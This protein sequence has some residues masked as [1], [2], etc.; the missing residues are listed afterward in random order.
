MPRRG[1]HIHK[2]KDGRWEARY[3][4]GIDANG[5]TCYKSV[6][7]KTYTE[8]KEKLWNCLKNNPKSE[9][10]ESS[11]TFGVAAD[12]WLEANKFRHKG[13][14][15]MRYE[16]L[17]N[18]HIKPE[19]QDMRLSKLNST[20]ISDFMNRK[21]QA[22]RL[23]G[24]GGL[25]SSYVRSI[26]L[27]L[28][29]VINFSEEENLCPPI[30]MKVYRKARFLDCGL[31]SYAAYRE[32]GY[33]DLPHIFLIIDNFSAFKEVYADAYEDQFVYLTRE[34]I[35]CGISI[36]VT[37]A[38]TNGLGY[39]YMSN[40]ACRLSF[41]CNDAGEY[42]NIFDRCRM[43]P[44]DVPGR[45]LCKLSKELYE[46]QSFIAF[47]GEKELDRS[48]AAKKF[49]DEINALYPNELA[50][51]IPNIPEVLTLDYIDNNYNFKAAGYQYPIALDYANVDVVALDLKAWNEFCIIGKDSG[52][53][54]AVTNS[55]MDAIPKPHYQFFKRQIQPL[56]EMRILCT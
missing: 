13:A 32:A 54:L 56:V 35:S 34:G 25:S 9:P 51:K 21:V 43:Q 38:S 36:I 7:A 41:R 22:G 6:Y 39:R 49:V 42:M 17:I 55:I 18:R 12:L 23:D 4:C 53:K 31:S 2:R 33:T 29:A 30:Q 47:E 40:F 8:V 16:N 52:K 5:K 44:K 48:N 11:I 45:M 26:M 50:R 3:K 20:V 10:S 24:N 46:M 19:L 27:V 37:N 15:I 14:T 1:E 28:N